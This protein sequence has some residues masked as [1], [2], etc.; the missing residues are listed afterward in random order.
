MNS[1]VEQRRRQTL[2]L[3]DKTRRETR[4]ELSRLD[5]ERVVHTDERAWRVRDVVGHLGVWNGEA[6]H[7]L[8]AYSTGGEYYCIG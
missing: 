1:S 3:L 5:P 2:N 4:S 8:S 7:S 6:A